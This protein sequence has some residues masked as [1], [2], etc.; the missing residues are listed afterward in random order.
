MTN[1]T[2]DRSS[3]IELLTVTPA[4]ELYRQADEVRR[5]GVGDDV[6]LRGLI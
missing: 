1:D 2:L 6:H 4:D 3:I 5:E